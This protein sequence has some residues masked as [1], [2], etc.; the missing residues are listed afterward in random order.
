MPVFK[1]IVYTKA[2]TA[3]ADAARRMETAET[4][5]KHAFI[6]VTGQAQSF[7][8]SSSQLVSVA[9]GAT[10]QLENVDLSQLYFKNTSAG[11]NGTVSIFGTKVI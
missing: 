5:L 9:A 11:Q 10:I 3:S 2:D 1:T 8:D 7:G 4:I 6:Q